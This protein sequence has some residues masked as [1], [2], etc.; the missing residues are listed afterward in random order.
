MDEK[1]VESEDEP[2]FEE[3]GGGDEGELVVPRSN[4]KSE[5]TLAKSPPV[6]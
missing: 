6:F 1:G 2:K 3:A 4:V 5:A